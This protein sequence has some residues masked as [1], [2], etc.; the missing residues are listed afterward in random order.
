MTQAA[1]PVRHRLP[2]NL[3]RRAATPPALPPPGWDASRDDQ[4]T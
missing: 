2:K 3:R 4:V 1:D